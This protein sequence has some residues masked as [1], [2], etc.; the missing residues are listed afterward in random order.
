MGDDVTVKVVKFNGINYRFWKMQ[1]TDFLRTQKL[2]K[3]LEGKE[4]KPATMSDADWEILDREAL[5]QIRLS[6]AQNVH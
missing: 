5:S 2:S 3:P 6:I 1:I 4:K